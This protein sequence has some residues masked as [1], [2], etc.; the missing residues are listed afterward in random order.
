MFLLQVGRSGLELPCHE[1]VYDWIQCRWEKVVQGML[2]QY[3]DYTAR[4]L[5]PD[6]KQMVAECVEAAA[7]QGRRFNG[8]KLRDAPSATPCSK[9]MR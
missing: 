2:N 8:R 9:T 7:R 5:I 1:Q 6:F 3:Y 4:A